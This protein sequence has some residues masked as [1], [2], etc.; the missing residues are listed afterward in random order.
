MSYYKFFII[1]QTIFLLFQYL[2]YL[3]LET[4]QYY[5]L[6][7]G[8]FFIIIFFGIFGSI[9]TS[10]E[11]FDNSILLQNSFLIAILYSI[12]YYFTKKI[13]NLMNSDKNGVIY[14]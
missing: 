2:Y 7:F 1:I 3:K 11:N 4:F 6:I 8:S 13:T 9:L 5:E 14:Y 12:W 10:D